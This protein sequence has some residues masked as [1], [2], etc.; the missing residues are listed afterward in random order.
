ML[1]IFLLFMT[2]VSDISI[3]DLL[4]FQAIIEEHNSLLQELRDLHSQAEAQLQEARSKRCTLL[5][6]LEGASLKTELSLIQE[7]QKLQV[8]LRC[9]KEYS[10]VIQTRL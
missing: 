3:F 7:N 10:Q 8:E 2:H 1:S 6:G 4:Y 5:Q 9:V